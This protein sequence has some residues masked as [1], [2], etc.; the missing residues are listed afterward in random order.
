MDYHVI[1]VFTDKLFGGSPAGVCMLQSWPPGGIMQYIAAENNLPG[2]AFLV[3]QEDG[4]YGLRWFT[5]TLEL[6]LCGHA[7]MA[8]AF[9]LFESSEQNAQEL[10]FKTWSGVLSVVR[11]GDMLQMSLPSLSAKESNAYPIIEKAFGV[12][13][14]SCLESIDILVLLES[15][16]AV[17]NVSPDFDMIRRLK[18]DGGL[19]HDRFGVIVTA[20]GKDSDYVYRYF[21]PNIGVDEDPATGR[22][23]CTLTPFWSQRLGKKAMTV[24]QLSARGGAFLCEDNGEYVSISGKSVRYLRGYIH[25]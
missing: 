8:S 20:E 1:D 19:G 5:P 23:N 22:A 4:Y 10:R 13:P 14:I 17:L 12:K 6:D 7:T 18:T 24:K 25:L 3:K 15:E 21:A 2:T 11:K 9:V 16:D